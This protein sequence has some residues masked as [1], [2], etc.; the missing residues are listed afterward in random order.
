MK[1][2]EKFANWWWQKGKETWKLSF[3]VTQKGLH[4][5]SKLVGLTFSIISQIIIY[6]YMHYNIFFVNWVNWLPRGVILFD[7]LII[8]SFYLS[9]LPIVA[10]PVYSSRG[11]D[12]ATSRAKH[13]KNDENSPSVSKSCKEP[14]ILFL[15][16]WEVRR[17]SM[18]TFTRCSKL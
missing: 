9:R 15:K 18:L 17:C 13:T 14:R 5:W 7:L 2:Q 6:K 3:R 10:L 4:S 16:N 8:L 1:F 11:S 12:K